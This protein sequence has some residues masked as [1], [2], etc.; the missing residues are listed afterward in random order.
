M[1]E[2]DRKEGHKCREGAGIEN[3][4]LEA[5]D[6]DR[7]HKP[8][9]PAEDRGTE[10]IDRDRDLGGSGRELH[11]EGALEKQRVSTVKLQPTFILSTR[12]IATTTS[13]SPPLSQPA[14]LLFPKA[15]TIAF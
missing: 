15:S 3:P 14:I 11:E 9:S 4:G 10:A 13:G 8:R 6:H 12:K 7:D 5:E 2:L 1:R